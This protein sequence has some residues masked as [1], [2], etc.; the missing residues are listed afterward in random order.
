M[1]LGVCYLHLAAGS[2]LAF[3][4]GACWQYYR[5]MLGI[6]EITGDEQ[7][8]GEAMEG[9]KAT[10]WNMYAGV[11]MPSA[12]KCLHDAFEKQSEYVLYDK[13]ANGNSRGRPNKRHTRYRTK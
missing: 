5:H 1:F 11:G 7:K 12:Q 8:E 10:L 9:M 13:H 6:R 4:E 2:A 3:F